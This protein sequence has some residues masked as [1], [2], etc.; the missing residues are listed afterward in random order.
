M[1]SKLI[2]RCGLAPK[3]LPV[4]FSYLDLN[5]KE[6]LGLFSSV[7]G[8]EIVPERKLTGRRGGNEGKE[9]GVRA[10]NARM[11]K[12]VLLER[13]EYRGMSHPSLRR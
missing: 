4:S 7:A 13:E 11:M 3:H 9:S 8:M 2:Y 12:S 5:L 6:M 1:E 10:T